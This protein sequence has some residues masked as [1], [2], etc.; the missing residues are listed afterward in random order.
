MPKVSVIIPVY[1]ASIF[2]ENC[3]NS[4][5]SQSLGDMQ[6]VFVDDCSTDNSIQIIKDV[7][8]QYPNR[9]KQVKIV[10]QTVNQG[11]SVARQRGLEES[12]GEFVIHCDADDMMDSDMYQIMYEEAIKQNAEI[13]FCDFM[14]FYNSNK[15]NHIESF[16]DD[17]VDSPS[18][19][20][21]PIEGAV[22]NKLIKRDLIDRNSISFTP[23]IMVGEDFL[24]VIKC[25]ILSKKA[26]VVHQPLYKYCQYNQLSI[27]RV[28]TRQ[29]IDTV[30][31]VA[32]LVENFIRT[33]GQ[34]EKY[35]FKLNYLKFQAKQFFIIYKEVRDLKYWNSLFPEIG[36]DYMRFP[37]AGYLKVCAWLITHN[38]LRITRVALYLKDLFY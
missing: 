32:I 35:Q 34:S 33:I 17:S 7:L 30:V 28:Y 21:S 26:I 31:Q 27:T 3:C 10:R 4:L 15:E 6:F 13:V 23:G 25:R 5:F 22:W 1:N 8:A 2:L 14:L 24:F 20:I 18:F 12:T 29:K 19:N 9:Q 16:P 36:E 37:V 38:L 11:V